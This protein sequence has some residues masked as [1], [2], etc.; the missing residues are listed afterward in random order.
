MI[1][2][3]SLPPPFV[4][5]ML[6]LQCNNVSIGF[7]V[8][9]FECDCFSVLKISVRWQVPPRFALSRGATCRGGIRWHLALLGRV[10]R[11]SAEV[12]HGGGRA[13][14]CSEELTRHG[15]ARS[16]SCCSLARCC[17]AVFLSGDSVC[18]MQP[19]GGVDDGVVGL[20][21]LHPTAVIF[22]GPLGP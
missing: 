15:A 5:L 6:A 13:R 10:W 17:C 4:P 9:K 20:H 12:A 11:G 2:V 1:H 8:L 21:N 18:I 22:Q 3:S 14:L 7:K 16:W 19:G